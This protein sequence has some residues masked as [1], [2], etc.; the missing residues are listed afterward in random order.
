MEFVGEEF[1]ESLLSG[2]V[3]DCFWR[4]LYSLS[5]HSL[6][7]LLVGAEDSAYMNMSKSKFGDQLAYTR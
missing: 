5:F 4:L 2:D 7:H 3:A 1:I 6:A